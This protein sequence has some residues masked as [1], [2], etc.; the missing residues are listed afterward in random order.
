MAAVCGLVITKSMPYRST[1][2]EWSSKYWLTGAPPSSPTA[3]R[4]LFDEVA[5]HESSLYRSDCEVVSGIGYADN[6][7]HAQS[8][9]TV[10]L[11]IEG[12]PIPGLLPVVPT[13]AMAGDQ[14]GMLE[15]RTARKNSRGKWVYLRKFMHRG[16]I[17]PNDPDYTDAATQAAY[18]AWGTALKDGGW[19][20]ARRI[21]SQ[22]FDEVVTDVIAS[23]FVTTRTLKR[24]GK[25]KNT[26]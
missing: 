23:P 11:R 12:Q 2:E 5:T 18:L 26:T 6:D 14:A 25:K 17:D 7:V 9:F 10:D 1:P 4:T 22:F 20:G 15:W 8:V 3:W 21:R 16:G 24:R 19:N 13:A